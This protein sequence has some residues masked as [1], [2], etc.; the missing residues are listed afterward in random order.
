[1]DTFSNFIEHDAVRELF[2]FPELKPPLALNPEGGPIKAFG[3]ERLMSEL[4]QFKVGPS[5]GTKL[6]GEVRWGDGSGSVRVR[7]SP[8]Y[9]V[10]V[11]RLTDDL[12]GNSVWVCKKTSRIRVGEFTGEEPTVASDIAEQVN[13]VANKNI[14]APKESYNMDALLRR[15]VDKAKRMTGPFVFEA[16]KHSGPDWKTLQFGLINSG[17]GQLVRQ[18]PSQGATPLA[19]LE[20]AFLRSRGI[21]RGIF[22]TVGQDAKSGAWKL[23]IPYFDAMF[24]PTQSTEE[25]SSILYSGIRLV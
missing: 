4:S 15:L 24:T 1:M 25:V 3:R 13:E 14:D 2:G 23:Q 12:N 20:V 16:V 11:E 10:M 9:L 22:T 19:L 21:V 6:L 17:V 8:N 18:T 7:L 5:N